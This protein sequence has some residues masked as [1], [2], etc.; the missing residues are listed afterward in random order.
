MFLPPVR[1]RHQFRRRV[2]KQ[3][4][5]RLTLAPY[6]LVGDL[7]GWDPVLS[8]LEA[9]AQRVSVEHANGVERKL[10]EIHAVYLEAFARITRADP[11]QDGEKGL[12]NKIIAILG[13]VQIPFCE[14]SRR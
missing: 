14:R 11:L 5:G 7:I 2:V 12:E 3:L 6:P 8:K 1:S 4:I 10:S 9:G 13:L